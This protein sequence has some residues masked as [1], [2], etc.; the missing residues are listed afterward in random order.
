MTLPVLSKHRGLTLIELLSVVAIIGILVGIL[1]PAISSIRNGKM[2]TACA[3]SMNRI[4]MASLAYAND[5]NGVLPSTFQIRGKAYTNANQATYLYFNYANVDAN[6]Y[7]QNNKKNSDYM[8]C[9]AVIDNL[10][11]YYGKN[12]ATW[13]AWAQSRFEGNYSNQTNTEIRTTGGVV[14]ADYY[15]SSATKTTRSS[16][17]YAFIF[18]QSNNY[19]SGNGTTGRYDICQLP[20]FS[21]RAT[22]SNM[23]QVDNGYGTK[24][25]CI[26]DG[27]V[28]C[29]D[30]SGAVSHLALDSSTSSSYDETKFIRWYSTGLSSAE[31]A[32]RTRFWE[33][34]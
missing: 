30:I 5:W 34:Y 20:N 33:G 27:R 17:E 14:K 21:H 26:T 29:F 18:C 19:N 3:T 25:L 31:S 24:Y 2:K 11:Q 9:P 22:L 32:K 28:N 6:L 8:R 10:N 1:I 23:A 13:P 16:K 12:T 15:N 7:A 4:G